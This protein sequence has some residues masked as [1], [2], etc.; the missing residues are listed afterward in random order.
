M[1]IC[2][3]ARPAY[4]KLSTKLYNYINTQTGYSIEGTF[5]TSN[6]KE[7]QYVKKVVN[8]PEIFEVSEFF[9]SN[10]NEFSEEKLRYFE[11]KY[12]CSPMWSI[13]YTDRFLVDRKID[14]IIKIVCGYFMFYEQIFCKRDINYYYDETLA[15]LSSYIA[16]IVAK[17]YGTKYIAQMAAR[18]WDSTRHYFLTDPFQYN[19]N[20][21]VNYKQK[22]Y[23][24]EIKTEVERFLNEFETKNIKPKTMEVTGRKPKLKFRYILFPLLYIKNRFDKYNNCKYDYIKYESYKSTCNTLKYYFRYQKSKKY[25]NKPDYRKKFVYLPLHYQPEASTLVCAQKYEKQLFFIDS[26]AKSLPLD[27]LLYVKEHYALLGHRELD[28]YNK[29][30]KYP[31]VVLINPYVDSRELITKSI[32]VTTLTGT[33]GWEAMLLRKPVFLGG[34]IFFDNAP[35]IIKINDI[36]CNYVDNIRKWRK[37]TREEILQYLYEYY[38]TTYKGNLWIDIPEKCF[39]DEN[40]KAL[41]ESLIDQINRMEGSH[42]KENTYNRC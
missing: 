16:Y 14:Y 17:Y 23:D 13:I 22:E 18:A 37:P 19:C 24:A 39:N 28:F 9:K 26:W 21:D 20:F 2:F 42:D 11:E 33:A 40:I 12:K 34:N 35:G 29:L 8:N 15:V 31:N 5:I 4:D 3:S 30:K 10:W 6:N 41:A 7:T 1:K 25:Y 32:A 38:S 27:T 36:Y